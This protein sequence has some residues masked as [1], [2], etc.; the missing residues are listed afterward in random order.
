MGSSLSTIDTI[1]ISLLQNCH[2]KDKQHYYIN[3]Y[4]LIPSFP[5]SKHKVI[6]ETTIKHL[7][8]IEVD[9]ETN[10]IDFR[11]N[12]PEIINI[13]TLPF[14]PIACI[15]YCLHYSLLELNLPIFPPSQI[16][17][18]RHCFFYKDIP[19]LLSF[20]I[21]FNAIKNYGICSENDMKT[22]IEH[23]STTIRPELIESAKKFRFLKVY[24][25]EQSL[26]VIR[27]VLRNKRPI[28][29]GMNI[30]YKLENISDTL[31]MPSSD[32]KEVLGGLGGVLVG[33]IEEREVFI[34][35]QT[36]GSQF[37]LSGFVMV[38]YKF[39]INRDYIYELYTLG[40]D[41]TRVE[42]YINSSKQVIDLKDKP[43]NSSIFGSLFN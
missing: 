26:G 35:A 13:N 33:F 8:N 18:Y 25:I 32:E 39:I 12:F 34:M 2:N 20:E 24:R 40:F 16:Y 43:T 11:N 17:I 4:N 23:L 6:T 28:L 42:G 31:W 10:Y 38:P 14:N 7:L 27:N 37:G 36:F 22:S 3:K 41:K 15:V 9:S 19:G 29:I 1:D 30:N 21:I 5:N